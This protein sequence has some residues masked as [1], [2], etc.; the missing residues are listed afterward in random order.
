MTIETNPSPYEFKKTAERLLLKYF[1]SWGQSSQERQEALTQA[2]T[3]ARVDDS[4]R[5][6]FLQELSVCFPLGKLEDEVAAIED[7]IRKFRDR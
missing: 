2:E 1:Q 7:V 6:A 3:L 5:D 4:K